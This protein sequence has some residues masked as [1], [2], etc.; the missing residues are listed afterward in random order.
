LTG[1]EFHASLVDPSGASGEPASSPRLDRRERLFRSEV[2]ANL[3]CP[4]FATGVED[5]DGSAIG[6]ERD[7]VRRNRGE[8]LV[9]AG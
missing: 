3:C 4:G 7:D 1:A 2:L 9:S 6:E 5:E 8:C